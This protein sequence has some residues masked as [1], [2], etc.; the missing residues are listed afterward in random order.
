MAH[1]GVQVQINFEITS[2]QSLLAITPPYVR[3]RE[4]TH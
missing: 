3:P 2:V 1:M 4:A